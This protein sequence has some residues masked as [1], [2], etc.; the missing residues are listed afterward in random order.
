MKKT[1]K[2]PVVDLFYLKNPCVSCGKGSDIV[3]SSRIRLAR[4]I[5]GKPFPD[6]AESKCR[7]EIMH[8]LVEVIFSL[9][10]MKN[11]VFFDMVTLD[12]RDKE[13]LHERHFISRELIGKKKGCGVVVSRNGRISIMINEED[14]LRMQIFSSGLRVDGIFDKIMQLDNYL[15]N[16]V[17][18]AFSPRLGY[19]T[20]CPTNVGTGL[21]VSVMI[22]LL[23]LKLA[24]ELGPVLKGLGKLGVAVRGVGGEGTDALGD[25]F[26]VSNQSTLGSSEKNI[27]D[28][29]LSAVKE[30]IKHEENARARLWEDKRTRVIDF[31]ARS[32]GLL[33]CARMLS[34]KEA[35]DL[36]SALRL[37]V[38]MGLVSNISISQIN[39]M[40]FLTQPAHIQKIMGKKAGSEERDS[41]RSI[42]VKEKI[43]DVE[44]TV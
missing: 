22:H 29:I 13:I 28:K 7:E 4:N 17:D 6:W 14:H 36:L 31:V 20:A 2:E 23:G 24:N 44:M 10:E 30:I 15:E 16:H 40:M 25:L 12:T 39:E 37:G 34:S 38:Y 43:K 18:F 27:V 19:L 1:T 9:P 21:R 8:L 32:L 33:K 5:S 42:I 35:F 11:A 41:F 3:I 26:Q